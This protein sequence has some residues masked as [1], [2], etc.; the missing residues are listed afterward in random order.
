MNAQTLEQHEEQWLLDQFAIAALPG[1]INVY[2]HLTS[3]TTITKHAYSFARAMLN[4]RQI[5]VNAKASS[6][7]LTEKVSIPAK[8]VQHTPL[9][10]VENFL[11]D[12]AIRVSR[13]P[14]QET[15]YSG[16]CDVIAKFR[17][18]IC[19]PLQEQNTSRSI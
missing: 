1:C 15:H 2:P 11:D 7:T 14:M 4:E 3:Y 6:G 13:V 8:I 12:I 9:T 10:P 19:K 16:F 5:S 18:E 17:G